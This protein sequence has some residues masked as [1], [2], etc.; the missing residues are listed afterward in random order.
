MGSLLVR[1]GALVALAA[2]VYVSTGCGG[3]P[4]NFYDAPSAGAGPPVASG[5][6]GT[7]ATAGASSAGASGSVTAS[8]GQLASAGSGGPSDAGGSGGAGGRAGPGGGMA[9]TGGTQNQGNA[10]CNPVRDVSGGMSGALGTEGPICI[11]V[12]DDIAGGWGCSSF[13]GRTVKVNGRPVM[14]MDFPLPDKIDGA[15]YFDISAGAHD[16][17]SIYWF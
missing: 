6:A 7:A 10:P 12:T 17:A 5:G 3:S 13:D 15:Y 14:C 11:R 2:C 1:R 9:G 16:Y 8:G 4:S